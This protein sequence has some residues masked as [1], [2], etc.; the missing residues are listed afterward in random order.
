MSDLD[1]GEAAVLASLMDMQ[2]S[3]KD[4]E[5]RTDH[6]LAPDIVVQVRNRELA[7]ALGGRLVLGPRADGAQGLEARVELPGALPA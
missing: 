5:Q 7:K 3:R 1:A 2:E 4:R 6:W